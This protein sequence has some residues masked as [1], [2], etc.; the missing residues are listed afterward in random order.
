M[1]ILDFAVFVVVAKRPRGGNF[2]RD[3]TR[4]PQPCME[5][6]IVL[7]REDLLSHAGPF[8]EAAVEHYTDILNISVIRE[9]GASTPTSK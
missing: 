5:N 1:S 4:S 9:P 8:L 2:L 7:T 3:C 6:A